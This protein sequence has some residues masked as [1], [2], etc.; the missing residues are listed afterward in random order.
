GVRYAKSGASL[1]FRKDVGGDENYQLYRFDVAT[2]EAALLTD[3]KSRNT[4][5]VFSN[6][7]DRIAFGS[8]KRNGADVD[9]WVVKTAE[10]GSAR[11]LTELS[12]GGWE[13]LDWSPD[14][15]QIAL[16]EGISA[17][18]SYLWLVD[19]A[20]GR[21]KLLTPKGGKETVSY[22]T[23]R[24]SKDGKGLYVATDKDSEFLRL[25]YVDLA[26]GKHTF[27]STQIPWDLD[28]LDVA[29]DGKTVA[30][31]TNEEGVGVLHLLDT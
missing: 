4:S 14:D 23:A 27:L 1:S 29:P 7:S 17:S 25:A 24:F 16:L 8:T 20:T 13:P 22:T 21:K 30:F 9:L 2:G 19:A 18:E 28:E 5:N 10:P 6:A 31:V 15:K 26:T 3:G 11:L 12:G